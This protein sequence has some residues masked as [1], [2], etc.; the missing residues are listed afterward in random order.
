M[1]QRLSSKTPARALSVR[2]LSSVTESTAELTESLQSLQKET[3]AKTVPWFLE[4]MPAAYFRAI[5]KEDRLEHLNAITS[6]VNAQQPEILLSSPDKKVYSYIRTGEQYPGLLSKIIEQLPNDSSIGQ[7]ARVKIFSSL[8]DTLA[9]DVFRFGRQ[10]PF[11]N[12][13]PEEKQALESL[14]EFCNDIQ[15]GKYKNDE[16]IPAPAPCFE[17]AAVESFAN[18][19]NT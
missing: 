15:Q 7:L 6:L 17:P 3:A 9:L 13:T 12:A 18:M 2:M 5:T 14:Q 8:D 11:R 16:S 19:C 4:N 10:E 1:L